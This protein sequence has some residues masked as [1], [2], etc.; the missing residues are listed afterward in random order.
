L[1][2]GLDANSQSKNGTTLLMAAIPDVQKVQL[3]ASRGAKVKTR[4]RLGADALTIAA[5]YRGTILSIRALLD[6]GAEVDPP[7][8]VRVRNAPLVLASMS[9]DLANVKLLL[10]RGAETSEKALAE[11]VTFGYPDVVRTLIQAGADPNLVEGSGVNLLHWATIANRADVI[12]VLAAA[13]VEINATDENGFTPLMYAATIDFGNTDALK[14]LLSA[15]ADKSI[16]DHEGRTPLA[17]AKQLGH[18]ALERAL[19]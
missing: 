14:A 3:L 17:Q 8:G 2:R 16:P 1:D 9:G 15:G 7:D 13:H 5:A 11:A 18:S 12:R 19:R 4:G 6:A 10:E